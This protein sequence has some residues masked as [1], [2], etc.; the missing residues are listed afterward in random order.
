[1]AVGNDSADAPAP[2]TVDVEPGG[3]GG[4]DCVGDATNLLDEQA[5]GE[6]RGAVVSSRQV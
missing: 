4:V 5:D 2:S 6:G 1:M 3:V